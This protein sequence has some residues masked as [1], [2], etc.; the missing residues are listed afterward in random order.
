V[1]SQEETQQHDFYFSTEFQD[2]LIL[3]WGISYKNKEW[4]APSED[5]FPSETKIFDK[6]AVQ[7]KFVRDLEHES[8]LKSIN[9]NLN[10]SKENFVKSLNFVFNIP[11]KVNIILI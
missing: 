9:I 1:D 7:T 10:I 11:G 8:K 4:V 5:I 3:H 6:K 2:D